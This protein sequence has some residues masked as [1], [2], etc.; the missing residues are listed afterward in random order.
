MN[1]LDIFKY[2]W[3]HQQSYD[4]IYKKNNYGGTVPL[5]VI[6]EDYRNERRKLAEEYVV[7]E[8]ILNQTKLTETEAESLAQRIT[9]KLIETGVIN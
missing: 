4:V 3:E 6:M 5:S 8:I 1:E 2:F 9:R 7:K